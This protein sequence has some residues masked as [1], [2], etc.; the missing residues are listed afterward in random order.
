MIRTEKEP[1][2]DGFFLET[3]TAGLLYFCG[4]KFKNDANSGLDLYL[5][6]EH[7]TLALRHK[8]IGNP[9]ECAF[10]SFG[11]NVGSILAYS[12]GLLNLCR[13]KEPAFFG[14]WL[15]AAH[16]FCFTEDK[17]NREA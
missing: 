5:S 12:C 4:V 2:S 1:R 7:D 3:I 13:S 15:R 8:F 11:K 6:K 14:A 10:L 17:N 9:H 16:F